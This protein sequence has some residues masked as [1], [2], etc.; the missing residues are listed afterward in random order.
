MEIESVEIKKEEDE[1]L[2][3]GHAGFIKTAEDLYEAMANSVPGIKFGL[4]FAEASG[5][6]LVRSEGNDKSLIKKAEQNALKI[7]AGHTFVIIFKN[8]Y[9]INVVNAVKS[10]PEVVG[11][12]CAT[13]N[14]VEVV[15]AH[16]KNGRAVLG[17]ADGSSAKGVEKEED[18]AARRKLLRDIGYKL[19]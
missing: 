3:I 5:P 2:I 15:L 12:Y 10:V 8:A 7:G 4:A 13:A 18:K 11:I 1:Q 16:T 19:G 17:V 6:C 9:P 14:N